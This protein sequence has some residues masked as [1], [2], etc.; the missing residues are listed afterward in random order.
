MVEFCVENNI[1]FELCGKIVLATEED[2]LARLHE[3]L[4]RGRANG[5]EGLEWL[6]PEEIRE[7]EPHAAAW[8]LFVFRKKESSTTL[9]SPG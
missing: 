3:L 8:R 4:E 1:P 9:L 5:L 6:G 2:E 7:L